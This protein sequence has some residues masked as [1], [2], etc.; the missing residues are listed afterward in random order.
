MLS[1]KVLSW[2]PVGVAGWLIVTSTSVR[3]FLIL[4]ASGWL[5]VLLGF[6]FNFAG[7]RWMQKIVAPAAT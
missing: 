4:S 3:N 7:R 1:T 2:A 6:G 5:C